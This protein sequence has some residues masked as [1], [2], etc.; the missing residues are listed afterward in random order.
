MRKNTPIENIQENW[1][2]T[3]L[4]KENKHVIGIFVKLIFTSNPKQNNKRPHC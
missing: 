1:I 3:V 2:Q 4:S